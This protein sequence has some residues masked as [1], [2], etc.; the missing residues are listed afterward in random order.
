MIQFSG[1]GCPPCH[2]SLP[3]LN[4]LVIDYKDKSF[5][6]VRVECWSNNIDVIKRYIQANDIKYRFLLSDR[7]IEKNYNPVGSVPVTFI[8][9]NNRVIRNVIRGYSKETT[10]KEIKEAIDKLL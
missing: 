1:I 5:E 9:D 7:E 6:L 8:L 10:E 4:R 2:V 3:F